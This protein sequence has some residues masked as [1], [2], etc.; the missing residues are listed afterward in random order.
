MIDTHCHVDLYEDPQRILED[1]TRQSIITIAVTNL[2]SY[3]VLGAPYVRT[4]RFTRLALGLH[5]LLAEKHTTAEYQKFEELVSTTSYI[6]E[7]GLDYS[8]EGRNTAAQQMKSFRFVL[9]HI[10][11]RPR[12]VTLHS[13][14]AEADVLALLAEYEIQAAVFHWYSGPVTLIDKILAEGHYF[15]FNPAMV[16]SSRGRAIIERVSQERI[17]TETDGP[18][19]R[20]GKKIAAPTNVAVVLEYLARIWSVSQIEAEKQVLNNFQALLAPVKRGQA[21]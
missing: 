6:G 7:V 5:P 3:F 1:I 4:A 13:R 11:D 19:V 9:S 8:R 20:I 21:R 10:Q 2:P 16:R 15:S 14:G 17:L 18:Y 12:F